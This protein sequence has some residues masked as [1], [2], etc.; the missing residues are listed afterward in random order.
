MLIH[1]HNPRVFSRAQF[2]QAVSLHENFANLHLQG[3]YHMESALPKYIR[4]SAHASRR[5]L[6]LLF[7]LR[8]C[9]GTG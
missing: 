2:G 7:T 4:T 5:L 3:V 1:V 8:A 6:T 9:V